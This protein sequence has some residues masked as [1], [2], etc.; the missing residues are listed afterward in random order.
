MY[1]ICQNSSKPK[2]ITILQVHDP[3]HTHTHDEIETF[4]ETLEENMVKV[5]KQDIIICLGDWG[6][7]IGTDAYS[8]WR[9]T[10]GKC[11]CAET[12]DR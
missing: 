8:N 10:V 7:N 1:D 9:G 2:N 4:D 6:A 5:A 3:T 11:S 12:N